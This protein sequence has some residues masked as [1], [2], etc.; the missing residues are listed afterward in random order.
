MRVDGQRFPAHLRQVGSA[1]HGP[2][3]NL[4]ERQG[5]TLLLPVQGAG[6]GRGRRLG[7]ALADLNP[8]VCLSPLASHRQSPP[9][10][11]DSPSGSYLGGPQKATMAVVRRPRQ[12]GHGTSTQSPGTTKSASSG[13][14]LFRSGRSLLSSSM[15]FERRRLRD[16]GY[17]EAV[18]STLLQS[19]NTST[20]ISYIRVWKMF[21]SW[22]VSRMVP[23][24]RAAVSDILAFLQD[25]LAKGLSCSSLRVQVAALGCFWGT[26]EGRTLSSHPDI[27]RFLKGAKHLC[28]PLRAPCPS[29]NLKV[30]LKVLGSPPFEPLKRATLKDLTLKVVFLVAITLA[31]MVSKLQALSCREPFLRISDSGVSL[32]TVPS[33]LP[34][35]V[36]SFHLNQLVELP[37]FLH[38]DSS[39]S[40]SKELKKLDVRQALLRYLEI[41]NSFRVSD[42]LS[43]LW[44]G[45]KKGNMASKTTIS[46]WLK[47]AINLAYL[48]TGRPLPLGVKV[49]STRSQA[50]SWAECQQISPLEICKAATWKSLHTFARHYRL[51]VQDSRSRRVESRLLRF[52]PRVVELWYIPGVWTDPVS[53]GKRK[54]GLTFDNFCSCSTKDQSRVPPTAA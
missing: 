1:G 44:K 19:R 53:T 38:L 51:D 11:R 15:A 39:D 34:K 48:L 18:M 31:W 23:P 7:I 12:S 49:H 24:V 52:P 45:P 26:V 20:S 36:A 6:S 3:G 17:S 41:T 27:V 42:H 25:G 35:V 50:A 14:S 28:P 2:D 43:V 5:S 22:C 54:L 32:R 10:H 33:F 40:L 37:S 29:W 21:E 13:T 47:E 46:R 4:S 8:S 9:S 16:K 30:V